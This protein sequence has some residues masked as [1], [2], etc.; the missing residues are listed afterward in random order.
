MIQHTTTP[1]IKVT[2]EMHQKFI[3]QNR[4]ELS[5]DDQEHEFEG[6]Y[7]EFR[8]VNENKIF[9]IVLKFIEVSLGV[10]LFDG[11]IPEERFQNVK[12]K[13]VGGLKGLQLVVLKNVPADPMPDES[14]NTRTIKKNSET[15]PS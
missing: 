9:Q 6:K 10:K 12:P 1:A 11:Y 14:R 7:G 15:N 13:Y 8:D 2:M 3:N 4:H 5:L